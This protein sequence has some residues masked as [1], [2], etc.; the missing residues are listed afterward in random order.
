MTDVTLYS[1][2]GS[3]YSSIARLGLAEKRVPYRGQL[4]DIGPAMKNYEPEYML[5]RFVLPRLVAATAL[6]TALV[7]GLMTVL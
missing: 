5:G 2:P 1:F 3:L 7:W 6:G 4:V